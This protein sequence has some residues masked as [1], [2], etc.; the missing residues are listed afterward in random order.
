MHTR[1]FTRVLVVALLLAALNL[2]GIAPAQAITTSSCDRNVC[3][4]LV[5]D[6]TYVRTATVQLQGALTGAYVNF[7]YF[8]GGGPLRSANIRCDALCAVRFDIYYRYSSGSVVTGRA[9]L[10]GVIQ[11]SPSQRL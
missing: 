1:G 5:R 11:G 9:T 2:V 8:G 10:S 7:N 3:L 4:I 6:G